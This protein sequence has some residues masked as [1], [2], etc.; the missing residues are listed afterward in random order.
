MGYKKYLD[1]IC[2]TWSERDRNFY[3]FGFKFGMSFGIVVTSV[4]L[5]NGINIINKKHSKD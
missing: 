2:T 5:T 1:T 3:K 4:V